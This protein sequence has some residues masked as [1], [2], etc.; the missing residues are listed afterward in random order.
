MRIENPYHE[1]ELSVQERLGLLAEGERNA[2][3]ISDTIVKGAFKFIGQQP[4]LVLASIDPEGNLWASVLAGKP[5]LPSKVAVAS[6]LEIPGSEPRVQLASATP[7][8]FVVATVL[9]SPSKSPPPASTRNVTATSDV[10]FPPSSVTIADRAS[11][12]VLP[13]IP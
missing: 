12:S 9:S 4:M 13:A 2:R 1:G 11:D 8:A 7:S 6:L 3:A 10:G 5:G